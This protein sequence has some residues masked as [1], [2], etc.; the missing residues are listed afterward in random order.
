[1]DEAIGMVVPAPAEEMA[2]LRLSRVLTRVP[3][4]EPESQYA[5]VKII[6]IVLFLNQSFSNFR[7]IPCV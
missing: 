1:M 4:P 7:K 2:L 3:A 5:K 6:I